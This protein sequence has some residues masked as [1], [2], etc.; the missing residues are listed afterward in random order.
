[1][2]FT[3]TILPLSLTLSVFKKSKKS[4]SHSK[5]KLPNFFIKIWPLTVHSVKS[6][7]SVDVIFVK[8]NSQLPGAEKV[9][10]SP[11]S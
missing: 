8:S 2:S 6:E 1:M 7:D 3:T 5:S 4:K 11:N 10:T 9:N